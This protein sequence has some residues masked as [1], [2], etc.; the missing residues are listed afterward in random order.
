VQKEASLLLGMAF[1][2]K[3]LYKRSHDVFLSF[4]KEHTPDIMVLYN[5]GLAL[6]RMGRYEEALEYL[7]EALN[8]DSDYEEALCETG[9]AYQMIGDFASAR[10][11]FVRTLK[12]D[13]DEPRPYAQLARMAYDRGDRAKTLEFIKRAKEKDPACPETA[14]V[15][16]YIQYR[17]GKFEK[18]RKKLEEC[19]RQTPDHFEALKLLARTCLELG[20]SKT[21][22]GKYTAASALNPADEECLHFLQNESTT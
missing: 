17:E 10:D 15:E 7:A 13:R 6:N 1:G 11:F 8:R 12:I 3:G 5:L 18:A 21:A 4:I 14:L 16:G 20:D 22:L 9:I 2:K 19:L